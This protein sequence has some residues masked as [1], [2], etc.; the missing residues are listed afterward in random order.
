VS[1]VAALLDGMDSAE[2]T[3]LW[4][5][6]PHLAPRGNDC[7]YGACDGSGF[8]LREEDDTSMPCRCREQRVARARTG[9]LASQI[10]K[11]YRNV[12]F[13]RHPIT[14]IDPMIVRPVRQ[15]AHRIEDHMERGDSLGLIGGRGNGKTTLAMTLPIEAMRRNRTVAVY[16]GPDLL[17]AIRSTYDDSTY[18]QLMES[19][20][21]VDLLHIEDLAVARPTE[22]VLEQLYTVINARYQDER[23]VVFT[24]D[25]QQPNELGAHI[26]ERTSSRLIEMC[27]ERILQ[28]L[29]PDRR[30]QP[31]DLSAELL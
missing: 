14:K 11:K 2:P 22:W 12:G 4:G 25:V 19:L 9:K 5:L 20:V 27:G 16:T 29:G 10:P 17:T 1:A 15:F 18:S 28:M 6:N 23:S 24:A 26:G 8:V 3:S 13:D 21:A 31:G 30:T 7:P